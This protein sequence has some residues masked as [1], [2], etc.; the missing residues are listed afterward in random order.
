MVFCSLFNLG[1]TFQTPFLLSLENSL[2]LSLTLPSSSILENEYLLSLSWYFC[3][4]LTPCLD[5]LSFFSLYLNILFGCVVYKLCL[6]NVGYFV[7]KLLSPLF[8]I[9][10]NWL[11]CLSFSCLI[12]LF[13]FVTFFLFCV[14]HSQFCSIW[15]GFENNGWLQYTFKFKKRPLLS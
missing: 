1:A 14:K 5:T 4:F 2:S 9:L 8:C 15:G 12:V 6:Y 3:L 11:Y 10:I 7:L 13:F